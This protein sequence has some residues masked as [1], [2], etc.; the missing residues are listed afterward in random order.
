MSFTAVSS[1]SSSSHKTWIFSINWFIVWLCS[2]Q[3]EFICCVV[4]KTF[5]EIS[6]WQ[7]FHGFLASP[8]TRRCLCV[9]VSFRKFS[10]WLDS[11]FLRC[12]SVAETLSSPK[13]KRRTSVKSVNFS[14]FF[15]AVLCS[16][17][18]RS[19]CNNNCY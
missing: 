9:F 3:C 8:T 17:K 10:F 12:T 16:H 15:F 18:L 7:Y 13:Q 4:V 2:S 6:S 11:I 19:I 5:H 14:V 1:T